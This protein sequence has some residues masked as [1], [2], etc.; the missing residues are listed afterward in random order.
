[1]INIPKMKFPKKYT[2]II[3]KYK[4][5]TP[6][7]KAKIEDDFIK[8]INDKDSEFY[9]SMLANMNEYELRTMLRMIPSLIDTGD[10]ND[11]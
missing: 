3:K 9:N 2:E 7:E 10:D 6:E 8:D 5:K 4:N 11:D 1:M